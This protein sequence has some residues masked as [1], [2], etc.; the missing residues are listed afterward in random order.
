MLKRPQDAD[1][2]REHLERSL[3]EASLG[4]DLD[5]YGLLRLAVYPLVNL[6]PAK[7]RRSDKNNERAQHKPYTS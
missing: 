5:R 3:P 1:F 7:Y 4:H 2:P 6:P